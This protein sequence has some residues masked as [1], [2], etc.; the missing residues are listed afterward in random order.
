MPRIQKHTK[1]SLK[2]SACS[3]CLPHSSVLSLR[4]LALSASCFGSSGSLSLSLILRYLS[5]ILLPNCDNFLS[6]PFRVLL[7]SRLAFSIPP[8]FRFL[9]PDTRTLTRSNSRPH[10]SRLCNSSRS[11]RH[12]VQL[13]YIRTVVCAFFPRVPVARVPNEES[14]G[15]SFAPT[16]RSLRVAVS[17][18]DTTR[19]LTLINTVSPAAIFPRTSD[20]SSL[21]GHVSTTR[22]TL[23][24]LVKL[25]V[26]L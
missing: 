9:F 21:D 25:I 26:H 3:F 1:F 24:F 23:G 6:S 13:S 19:V 17:S 7:I 11:I 5:S 12:S 18:G 16:C 14:C 20:T 4:R 10:L 15:R 8:L 22:Y 2:C